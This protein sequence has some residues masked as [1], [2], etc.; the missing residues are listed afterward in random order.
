MC[1][2][3]LRSSRVQV[4]R[5]LPTDEMESEANDCEESEAYQLHNNA[6]LHYGVPGFYLIWVD[7]LLSDLPG[8]HQHT[9]K[10]Y[11]E[12]ADVEED[13]EWCDPAR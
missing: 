2:R 13:E 6:E 1:P 7:G 3:S 12:G 10:L 5:P 9:K 8:Y 11:A 4:R